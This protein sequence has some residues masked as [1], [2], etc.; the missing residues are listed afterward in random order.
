MSPKPKVLI[1]VGPTASGKTALALRL[2]EASAKAGQFTSIISADSRQV[3]RGL[4]V[5]TGKDIPAEKANLRLFGLDL[6]DPDQTLN[7]AQ[8]S[9]Y[10]R[11]LIAKEIKEHR[12]VMVVG[13]TGFYL[14]ALTQ[15]ASLARVQPD[16]NLRQEL[17]YLSLGELQRRLQVTDPGRLAAMNQSDVA[18]PRRLIRAIEIAASVISTTHPVI[19]NSF[20]DLSFVWIGIRTPLADLKQRIAARVEARLDA[21]V[22]EVQDLVAAYPDRSLPIYTSLGVRPIL[23]FLDGEISRA[24]ARQL[25]TT[26]E[27]Q[28]AKRQLTW[29][30]KQQQIIWYDQDRVNSLSFPT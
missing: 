13:G 9:A 30:A 17:N 4:D 5:L 24:Q 29:F 28:Y 25:W 23:R 8:Y 22:T 11:P 12:Q 27:V 1:I 26:E 2:A 3:Y 15:P 10:A 20:Q 14:K 21:A 18:N 16:E 7:A 6:I 19:L